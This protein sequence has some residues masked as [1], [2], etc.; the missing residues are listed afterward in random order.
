MFTVGVFPS[1]NRGGQNADDNG[2]FH[3]EELSVGY[4]RQR[5]KKTQRLLI[6][7]NAA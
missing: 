5:I 3:L 6:S 2:G 7:I 1:S 4:V